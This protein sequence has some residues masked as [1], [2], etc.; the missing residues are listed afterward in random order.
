MEK[1]ASYKAHENPV[2]RA[3][4]YC[5]HNIL[6]LLTPKLIF[7]LWR[8]MWLNCNFCLFQLPRLLPN[9]SHMQLKGTYIVEIIVQ[10][11][12]VFDAGV[13]L[14]EDVSRQVTLRDQ[15]F[16]LIVRV[17]GTGLEQLRQRSLSI[18]VLV[19]LPKAAQADEPTASAE[20]QPSREALLPLV[21]MER[22]R[23]EQMVG[24]QRRV[25]RHLQQV[26]QFQG[27][28]AAISPGHKVAR[29]HSARRVQRQ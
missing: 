5:A 11:L 6:Y 7:A 10:V 18:A 15:N 8:I 14:G 1:E 22:H 29:E 24:R 27:E 4:D 20:S 17:S 13:D 16:R 26:R 25:R 2:Q 21:F 28:G 19:Q 23:G 12:L 3:G 9:S